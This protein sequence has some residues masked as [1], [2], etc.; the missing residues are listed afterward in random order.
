[1]SVTPRLLLVDLLSHGDLQVYVDGIHQAHLPVGVETADSRPEAC[2][3][4]QE[5]SI[6]A[7]LDPA[8]DQALVDHMPQLEWIHA[9]TSGTDR[10]TGLTY[11]HRPLISSSAG[12]HGPQMSELTLLHML[13]A[14][15]E[16]PK[17]LANAQCGRWQRWPQMM[18]AGRRVLILGVGKIAEA[19]ALRC[20][21]LDMS[22]VGMSSRTAAP[23]F[24]RIVSRERVAPEA[25]QADFVVV[26]LPYD[27]A[28]HLFVNEAFLRQ[29]KQGAILISVSRGMTVDEPA[30][31][32]ALE[33]G[34]LRHAG[35][36]VFAAEP[37]PADSPLWRSPQ[38]TVTPH[39][40]GM[41]DRYAQQA[42]P[43]LLKNLAA[44]LDGRRTEM[45]NIVG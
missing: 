5:C 22:V 29:M 24:D 11:A 35:L 32:R 44:F 12:I 21:A 9:L 1:L 39:V 42:L 43:V 3:K 2:S 10:I 16:F 23:G 45:L 17:M 18:L 30:L 38:V 41:S 31:L 36:D 33:S 7:I 26:L 6:L 19:L 40:G 28:N 37:L 34:H 20:K 4:G 25:A 14:A 13:S 15:R 27:S 8:I